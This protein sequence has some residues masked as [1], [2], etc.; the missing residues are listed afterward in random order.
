M[1]SYA[2][3][4]QKVLEQLEPL[5]QHEPPPYSY[6]RRITIQQVTLLPWVAGA[7]RRT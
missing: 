2:V 5:E 4:V 6:S 1:L 7:N 3:Q